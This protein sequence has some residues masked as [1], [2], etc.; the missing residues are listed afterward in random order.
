MTYCVSENLKVGEEVLFEETGTVA[1]CQV[2]GK[3]EDEV[4]LY[5]DLVPIR[6]DSN[7]GHR[8]LFIGQKFTIGIR[9]NCVDRAEYG[10]RVA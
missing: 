1:V 7:D 8:K 9:R 5:H 4:D 3:R 2:V 10:L 6:I